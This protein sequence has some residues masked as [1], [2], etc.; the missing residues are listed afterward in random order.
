MDEEAGTKYPNLSLGNVDFILR[1]K[2]YMYKANAFD[3]KYDEDAA[4]APEAVISVRPNATVREPKR[5]ELFIN[6]TDTVMNVPA[7]S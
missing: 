2:P 1:T 3:A 7:Q 5:D 6:C 4:Y